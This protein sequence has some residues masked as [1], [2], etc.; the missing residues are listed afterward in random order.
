MK[1]VD[2]NDARRIISN[3]KKNVQNDNRQGYDVVCFTFEEEKNKIQNTGARFK[4]IVA[5]PAEK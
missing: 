1:T 2:L 3:Q 5:D 4:G